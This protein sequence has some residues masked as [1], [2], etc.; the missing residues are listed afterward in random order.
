M[1]RQ[2]FFVLME[3]RPPSHFVSDDLSILVISASRVTVIPRRRSARSAHDAS[4]S[5]CM[6]KPTQRAGL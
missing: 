3:R 6:M 4:G 2:A 1:T 5:R